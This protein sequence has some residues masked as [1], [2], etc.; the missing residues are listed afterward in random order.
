MLAASWLQLLPISF[1]PHRLRNSEADTGGNH[2]RQATVTMIKIWSG[3]RDSNP[4]P[5]PWQRTDFCP[6]IVSKHAAR[7]DAA[8]QTTTKW[9]ARCSSIGKSWMFDVDA[10]LGSAG[11]SESP[12]LA[13][14]DILDEGRPKTGETGSGHVPH[15]RVND[16]ERARSEQ[17]LSK[18][19]RGDIAVGREA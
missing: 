2:Q 8:R 1:Q 14:A 18:A 12:G 11:P 16:A 5:Q 3:R 13:L 19:L 15:A 10:R 6:P 17:N 9:V 7:R 4:R